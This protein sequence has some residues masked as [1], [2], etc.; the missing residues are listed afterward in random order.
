[1]PMLSI[2]EH[3]S[4]RRSCWRVGRR[5]PGSS[6]PCGAA[7]RRGSRRPRRGPCS[8]ALVRVDVV[9]ALVR[10][11]VEARVVEDEELGLGAEVGRVADAGLLQVGL[12]LAARCSADRAS[13]VSRVI[14][15]HDVAD[16]HQRRMLEERVDERRLR[17]GHHQ[18]VALV[19]RLPAADRGAVEAV[20]RPRTS[21]RRG[22]D[23]VRAVLPAARPVREAA[24][25]PSRPCSSWRTREP[26]GS[27]RCFLQFG[28]AGPRRRRGMRASPR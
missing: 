22:P 24:D 28:L 17:V 6:P 8:R 19:D 9:E 5:R 4:V 26:L 23:R 10:G 13:T 7:C 15:S 3:I 1:M 14:G 21:P 25:P 11:G 20:A 18:H 12:G 2:V 16:Q 27:H